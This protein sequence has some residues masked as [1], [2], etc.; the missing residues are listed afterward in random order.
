[1]DFS[2]IQITDHHICNS[3]TALLYG[4]S[5]E[6][7][8]EESPAAHR[9]QPCKRSRLH[10]LYR[11]C[12]EWASREAYRVVRSLFSLNGAGKQ[13]PGPLLVNAEGLRKY[14][15][16]FMPG[17]HDDRHFFYK[18]L[19]KSPIQDGPAGIALMNA[20][21]V[22]KG[23]QF[24]CLDWGP[25]TQAVMHPQT[26]DFLAEALETRLPSILLMHHHVTPVGSRWLDKFIANDVERFWGMISG[27]NILGIFFGHMHISFETQPEGIST[28]GLR[29]T[30]FTFVM[31]DEPQV[32]LQ[33]AQYRVV[34]VGEYG[35]TSQIIEVD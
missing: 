30:A 27:K 26:L 23:V 22:H 15:I 20:K 13:P 34:Q 35:L 18:E 7:A 19:F 3:D 8:F 21:F 17:N 4:D 29:S 2:F 9:Q 16:Y 33:P 31:K 32:I 25:E 1:M 12:R 24:V 5:P 28:F 14:P 11:G 6:F 10:H